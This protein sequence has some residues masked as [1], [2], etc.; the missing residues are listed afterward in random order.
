MR[1]SGS[2]IVA[3]CVAASMASGCASGSA[4]SQGAAQGAVSGAVGGVVAGALGA[5]IFGGNAGTIAASA[6]IGAGTGAAVGA[7]SGAMADAAAKDRK[8]AAAQQ[9]AAAKPVSTGLKQ[10]LD[11]RNLSAVTLLA[12]CRQD[13]AV[14]LARQAYAEATEKDQKLWALFIEAVSL[15]EKGDKASAASVYPRI[16]K[17][18]PSRGTAEKARA[19]A[20]EG[21][22]TV[23]KVRKEQGPPP[24]CG[25]K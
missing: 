12:Q 25:G 20:L 3:L 8:E 11:P 9:Q 14:V 15:E 21:L 17:T 6:V 13:D 18:D 23:Q 16:V 2:G 7:T 19:D 24:L 5:L 10:K 1:K 4:A 22:I